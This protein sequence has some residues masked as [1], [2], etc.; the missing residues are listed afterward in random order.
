VPK[1]TNERRKPA[2]NLNFS[3]PHSI[4]SPTLLILGRHR[5]AGNRPA[6]PSYP[7]RCTLATIKI[8]GADPLFSTQWARGPNSAKTSPA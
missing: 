8:T 2:V 3:D 5:I 1:C 7:R 4:K 6:M